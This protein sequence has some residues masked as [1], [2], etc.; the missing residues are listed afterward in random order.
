MSFLP[1]L[2]ADFTMLNQ[3]VMAPMR[4]RLLMAGIELKMFDHLDQPCAAADLAGK[5]SAHPDNT[6]RLLDG[7][8]ACGLLLKKNGRYQNTRVSHAYL[9]ESSRTYLGG[10]LTFSSQIY[11]IGVDDLTALIKNGPPGISPEPESGLEEMNAQSAD[12]MENVQRAGFA[13]LAVEVVIKLPE[14]PSMRKMLDLGGGPG[15]IAMA[16]VSA[17]PAIKGVVFD[18]PAVAQTAKRAIEELGMPDR[19]ETLGGD[20]RSDPIGSGYDL[21]W[22]SGVLNFTKEYIGPVVG[23]VY[24]SLNPGGVFISLHEGLTREG[25]GPEEFVLSKI[26]THMMGL[27]YGLEQGLI[28]D[29]MLDAGFRSVRSSTLDSPMGPLD[30]DIAR[31]SGGAPA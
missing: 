22:S 8:T 23:K 28:A 3:I 29:T 6:R 31:K 11:E 5:L 18:L 9:K 17:H 2:E 10:M 26:S 20:F 13:G 25:T 15:L 27:D 21:V 30:L 12:L 4:S 24:E 7:L 1:D 16:I 19:M 14:F